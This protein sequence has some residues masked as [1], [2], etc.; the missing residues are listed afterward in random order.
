VRGCQRGPRSQVVSSYR[1]RTTLCHLSTSFSVHQSTRC[2]TLCSSS[3]ILSIFSRCCLVCACLCTNASPGSFCLSSNILSLALVNS[4]TLSYRPRI[5]M[6]SPRSS[7]TT[8][9]PC[10][11]YTLLSSAHQYVV[12]SLIL[13]HTLPLLIAHTSQG[14]QGRSRLGEPEVV[15]TGY[16]HQWI[17]LHR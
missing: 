1:T 16:E 5:N 4:V 8:P 12:S 2:L 3:T 6:L 15:D 17:L 7:S 13:N 10:S 9:S 11:C 14:N